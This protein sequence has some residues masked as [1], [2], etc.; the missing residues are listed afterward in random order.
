MMEKAQPIEVA[1][2]P[3]SPS[4]HK[5]EKTPEKTRFEKIDSLAKLNRSHRGCPR[6]GSSSDRDFRADW[7]GPC[8]M[9]RG[10]QPGIPNRFK[11]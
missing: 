8:Q 7:C 3:E 11:R 4:D 2:E 10:K 9:V 1:K 6:I 5:V